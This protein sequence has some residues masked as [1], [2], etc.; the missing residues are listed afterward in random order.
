[1]LGVL[2][3]A[4]ALVRWRLALVLAAALLLLAGRLA[5]VLA[6]GVL[7]AGTATVAFMAGRAGCALAGPTRCLLALLLLLALVLA[8]RLLLTL[9]GAVALVAVKRVT[10]GWLGGCVG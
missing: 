1:M 9:A 2:L 10:A 4:M 3:G 6:V 7:V 8:A 5:L